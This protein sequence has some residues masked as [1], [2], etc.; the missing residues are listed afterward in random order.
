[1]YFNIINI[2][3]FVPLILFIFNDTIESLLNPDIVD[4][5]S[6]FCISLAIISYQENNLPLCF[7]LYII[8]LSMR[9]LYKNNPVQHENE[10]SAENFDNNLCQMQVSDSFLNTENTEKS[11]SQTKSENEKNDDERK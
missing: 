1:M 7:I 11:E 10:T 5:M 8:S 2:L 4:I 3:P 6:I 9:F